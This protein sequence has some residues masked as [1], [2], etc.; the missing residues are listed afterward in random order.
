[1]CQE[2]AFAIAVE[3]LLNI[4]APERAQYIRVMFAEVTRILNHL[5][6]IPAFAM[7]IGAA[8]PMLWAFE[9]RE[10]ILE[11]H[12]AV[13]GARFHAAYFRPGGVHQDLP[14][15]LLEKMKVYF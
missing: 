5:L 6:N 11:F 8:T 15:G 12:E 13:S 14:D 4:Q 3:D 2:H 9:E 1:M 10:K 7:D